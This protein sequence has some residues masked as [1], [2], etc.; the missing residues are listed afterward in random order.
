M[1][2]KSRADCDSEQFPVAI[3]TIHHCFDSLHLQ[4]LIGYVTCSLPVLLLLLKG[5]KQTAMKVGHAQD[6]ENHSTV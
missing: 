2:F 5:C 4:S 1:R 6:A 3:I